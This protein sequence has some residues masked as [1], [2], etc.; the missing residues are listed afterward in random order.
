[1]SKPRLT[2]MDWSKAWPGSEET[3]AGFWTSGAAEEEAAVPETVSGGSSE[4]Q[5]DSTPSAYDNLDRVSQHQR[6]EDITGGFEVS[7]PEGHA[8][9]C[10]E[11]AEQVEVGQTRDSS[12]SWSSCEVLPLDE[13]GDV[14][15]NIQGPEPQSEPSEGHSL[16]AELQKQMAQQ[17]AEYQA[18]IQRLER[19]NDILERQVAVLRVTLEQQK[20]S[21]SVAEIKIRNMEKAK[22]DADRRNST[23]QRE[24]ELFFQMYGEIK[25]RGEGG[26]GGSL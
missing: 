9:A 12:S 18:R 7:D 24:M 6:M 25:R 11:E 2:L 26:R 22:A 1:S 13:S 3:D 14:R 19:C 4:A 16:L 20:R 17:K 23:L 10:E 8:G 5:E 15:V 21:Q